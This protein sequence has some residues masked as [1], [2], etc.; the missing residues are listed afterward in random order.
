MPNEMAYGAEEDPVT[1]TTV[2]MFRNFG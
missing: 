2:Q 1:N